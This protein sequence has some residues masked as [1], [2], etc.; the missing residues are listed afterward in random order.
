MTRWLVGAVVCSLGL[1]LTALGQTIDVVDD[2]KLPRFEVASIRPGDPHATGA[3]V[4][5]P[6]GRFVQENMNLI[7]A[8]FLAFGVRPY[9]LGTLPDLMQRERFTI[10]AKMPEGAPQQDRALMLRALFVDRFKLRY[11]VER[12]DEDAFVLV[13]ARRDGRFGPQL[14]AS[15]VDCPARLAAQRQKQDVPPLP[16][17]AAECGVR[18]GPGVINF[19]G[20]P[21]SVL[22]QML[23]NQTTR[24]V[25]DRTGINGMVDVELHWA[26]QSTS[27]PR[28]SP[29]VA[30]PPPPDDAPSIFSA[31]QEQL[32]LKFDNGKAPVDH[33]VI[34][35]IE[36]PD[37]D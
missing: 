35:H 37:F 24:Q 18:N 10:N 1:S 7:S 26:L 29:D 30:L 36:R 25:V 11:H 23:S 32:G 17:G 28:A 6:P 19:G 22:V 3:R 9:Q 20:M 15:V 12:K 16:P 4:G 14:R 21:M 27:A 34:D 33:L 8:F 5:F 13:L 2:A 31:V